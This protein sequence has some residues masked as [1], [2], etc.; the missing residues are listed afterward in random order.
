MIDIFSQIDL[1][2]VGIASVATCIFG[3]VVYF[4]NRKSVTS[5]FF[6]LFSLVTV[7]WGVVNYGTY[8][9]NTAS[10]AL[11]S[12]RLVMFF[13]VWQAYFLYVLFKVFPEE[14]FV[15]SKKHKYLLLPLVIFTSLITLTPIFFTQVLDYVPGSA[16]IVSKGIGLILF[17][18]VSVGLILRGLFFMI[19][20]ARQ[21]AKKKKEPFILIFIGSFLTFLLIIGL[22][23]ILPSFFDN[24][25]FVPLGALFTFPLVLFTSY[26][27]VKHK[28]LDIKILSTEVL[29]FMLVMM[30]FFEVLVA[31]SFAELV[32]QIIVFI[33]LL[34]LSIFLIKSIIKE[35]KQ[36]EKLERISDELKTVN[37]RLQE[38]DQQK[39]EFLSIASHQLR[40]PLSIIKG[41]LELIKDGGYG[42]VT[43]A[44]IEILDNMDESNQ[45]LVNLVDDFLNITR[46]E[47]GRTKF[48]Y[49]KNNINEMVSSVVK[50]LEPRAEQNGLKIV[51]KVPDVN[52]EVSCDQEKVRNVVFNFIDN[53]IKYTEKGQIVVILEKHDNGIV[54]RVRD[55]G[56]GFGP[57]DQANFFQKFYRG[58]NV[59]GT[60]VTGTGLGLY[61]CRKFIEAHGGE[62]WAKSSGLKKGSEFGFWIPFVPKPKK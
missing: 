55:T 22:N 24:V 31:R 58:V 49:T 41:Y 35:V 17:A 38:L 61:V 13:A 10:L 18:F 53:A 4:N 42:K 34:V 30:I 25:D 59:K 6:L 26:A 5:K 19:K 8:R 2:T 33:S 14:N 51:W 39:T 44:T 27:I 54:A 21:T 52:F 57:I 56:F 1:L 28:L 37:I 20:K 23:F 7:L 16:P 48:D 12:I 40:T 15:F 11:W 45:R 9:V 29:T 60:N 43:K 32:F 47:Q 36:K 62:V 50:E 3:F 46:I